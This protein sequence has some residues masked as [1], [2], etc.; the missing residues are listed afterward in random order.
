MLAEL[1]ETLPE[2]GDVEKPKLVFIFDEAHLLFADAPK[3]LKERIEQVVRLIRSKGVGIYF[4]TQNPLDIP[5]AV[6]GQLGNRIQHAL[7]AFTP[8]DQK[9]IKA[10][11]GT[12]RAAPGLDTESA[13]TDLAVGEALIS[14]LDAQG[15]PRPVER[16]LVDPP[17]T[18]LA[19]LSA[20]ERKQVIEQSVVF[21]HYE[22]AI[23]RE[24]AYE[25]LAARAQQP[26]AAAPS[27][28]QPN[29]RTAPAQK[30]D[31]PIGDALE[32]FAKSAMRAAGSQVGRQVM[33]GLFESMLGGPA[34]RKR[35]R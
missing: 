13:I 31:S 16:A 11:A 22:A 12:F 2:V 8:K 28:P 9:V 29:Q 27:V 20:S 17:T 35:R 30:D 3:A 7:R 4:A 15:V 19:A 1:F 34:P 21:G 32:A 33:R 5:D 24:S 23:D 25:Q 26:T 14:C 10:V 6:L 18:R